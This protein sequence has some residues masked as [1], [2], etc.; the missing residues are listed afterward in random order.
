M[1]LLTLFPL[2]LS[3]DILKSQK[4]ENKQAKCKTATKYQIVLATNVAADAVF[5][6]MLVNLQYF[7][8]VPLEK[9]K[10]INTDCQACSFHLVL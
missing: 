10:K 1:F 5:R 3:P 2:A 4:R 7:I 9:I 8:L 6:D